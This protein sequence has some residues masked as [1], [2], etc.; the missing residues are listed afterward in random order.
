MKRLIVL[1]VLL[2]ALDYV[3][4]DEA[5]SIRRSILVM[6]DNGHGIDTP[7][8][9]SPDHTLLEYQWTREVACDVVRILNDSGYWVRLTTPEVD[10]VKLSVRAKRINDM[11]RRYGAKKVLSIS[12]H[13]NA[14]GNDGKWHTAKGWSVFV[15]S[16]A[17]SRSKALC[18]LMYRR[19]KMVGRKV[20]RPKPDQNYWVQSLAMTRDVLCPAVL[21]ENYFQDNEDDCE[22][23][24]TQ[25]GKDS[26][27]AIVV[28]AVREYVRMYGR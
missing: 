4:A 1:F 20:R 5:D 3:Y 6:V 18:N 15:S 8:K 24:K 16:N 25:A 7:G 26:C 13:N 9:R 19:A 17:S 23:L 12:I 2:I 10:D 11:C 28:D 22:W 27:V 21:V 14:A